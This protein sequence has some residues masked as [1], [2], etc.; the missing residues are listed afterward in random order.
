M[1]ATGGAPVR[2]V[3]K[4][5]T[6]YQPHAHDTWVIARDIWNSINLPAQPGRIQPAIFT[7]QPSSLAWGIK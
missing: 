7:E 1:P 3:G 2:D 4:Y 5:V 6:I